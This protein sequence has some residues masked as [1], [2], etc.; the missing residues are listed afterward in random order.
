MGKQLNTG[1]TH[2][3]NGHVP[4]NKGKKGFS[5]NGSKKG[6]F[7]AGQPAWNKGKP[8]LPHLKAKL[9]S[10]STGRPP[11]NKGTKGVMKAWNKG[12]KM[13]ESDRQAISEAKVKTGRSIHGG[14]IR[15]RCVG[16]PRATKNGHYVF[17]HILVMENHLGRYLVKGE[18]VHHINGIRNDNRI[19][20]LELTNIADHSRHHFSDFLRT[21]GKGRSPRKPIPE[22]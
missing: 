5:P 20:N 7:K 22:K 3:P 11:W 15:L 18:M 4:W 8:M 9:I 2:F 16:H 17:E 1:R 12:K 10:L 14:Y 6:R 19:G 21:V 13:S